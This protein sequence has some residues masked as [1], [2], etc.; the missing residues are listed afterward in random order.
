MYCN[1]TYGDSCIV[2]TLF[3]SLAVRNGDLE[4]FGEVLKTFESRFQTE[5]TYTLIIRLRHNV[6]KTGIRMMSLSYSRYV[7]SELTG[8]PMVSLFASVRG[9]EFRNRTLSDQV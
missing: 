1:V 2:C 3:L 4:R 5:K 8:G 6:I 9:W 7:S